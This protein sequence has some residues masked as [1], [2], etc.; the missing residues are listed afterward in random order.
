MGKDAVKALAPFVR[1]DT[2][3]ARTRSVGHHH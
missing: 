3:N 1:I 2:S